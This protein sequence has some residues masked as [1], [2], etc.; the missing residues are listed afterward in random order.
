MIVV[1]VMVRIEGLSDR[2]AR[3]GS[4]FAARWTS[5]AGAAITNREMRA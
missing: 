5:A 1:M 4:R 3:S 2:A